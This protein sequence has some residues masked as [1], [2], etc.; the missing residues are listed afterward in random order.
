VKRTPAARISLGLVFVTCSIVVTL[1]L[2]GL[3]PTGRSPE[4]ELRARLCE[5]LAAQTAASVDR[6]DLGPVRLA[7]QVAVRRNDD[8]LS[9]AVRSAKGRLLV[10]AGDHAMLWGTESSRARTT[11]VRVPIFKGGDEWGALEVRFADAEA[12][13]LG[14]ALWERPVIKLV[15]AIG[16]TCFVAFLF[17]LRRT[18]KHL[19]PSSVIPTRVQVALDVM[20][21][22]VL[23]LDQQE[24]IVLANEA[25]AR[26]A[27]VSPAEL[28]G[29][30]ASRLDWRVPESGDPATRLPWTQAIREAQPRTRSPLALAMRDGG[31]R[32]IMVNVAPVLDGW[33]RAK[34]A[35]ATFDDVTELEERGA[36]LERA[37][38]Q[39]QESQ[40][41]IR[42]QNEELQVLARRDPLTGVANRRA[43]VEDFEERFG[44]AKREGQSLACI[45]VDIDHF[46]NVN[47]SHG[48]A[49]G[50]SVIRAVAETL[51]VSVV[52]IDHVCRYGGEEFC[53]ML[54]GADVGDACEFAEATRRRIESPAFT[55]VPVTASFG[56][57]TIGSG[58]RSP[59][60]LINQADEALYASKERGRNR[61]TCWSPDL[62]SS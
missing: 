60:E 22:G 7:L 29:E 53:V 49:M 28:L 2:V 16:A 55:R 25:F 40:E 26:W 44:V 33:D 59:A 51:Q 30:Q 39:L 1:D 47:D 41:E 10:A 32:S 56:V 38:K 34:G 36:R 52:S 3:T 11:H 20:Q 9:A 61:V 4:M 24:R 5:Q 57:S 31:T 18:L 48:H 23:L 42:L 35:I 14:E 21:E 45:M 62:R 27:G 13:G 58:A 17:Y 15:L 50:D 54:T 37:M 19:D 46:K 43:F 6:N 12:L 8:V